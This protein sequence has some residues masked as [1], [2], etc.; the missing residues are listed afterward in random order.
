MVPDTP[1]APKLRYWLLH[2]W[3]VLNRH[4]EV[5]IPR[6]TASSGILTLQPTAHAKTKAAGLQRH[7]R[8]MLALGVPCIA[9]GT[10]AIEIQ[11]FSRGHNHFATWHG[12]IMF[13][14]SFSLPFSEHPVTDF[15]TCVIRVARGTGDTW[16]WKCVVWGCRVWGWIESQD[17]MEISQVWSV[18]NMKDV[19][20]D[21]FTSCFAGCLATSYS[22]F[23]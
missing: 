10:L 19:N 13:L 5:L 8:T 23:S 18:G 14:S 21:S 3:S 1:S 11:K 9:L 12:V 4:H 22:L 2:L 20:E 15:R 17:D 16:R 6:L 7:Q